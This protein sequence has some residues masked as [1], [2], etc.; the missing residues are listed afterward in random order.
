ML[1][2]KDTV[3][4]I[5]IYR[6]YDW[7]FLLFSDMGWFQCC[8]LMLAILTV[9]ALC[10]GNLQN[11]TDQSSE[12]RFSDVQSNPIACYFSNGSTPVCGNISFVFQFRKYPAIYVLSPDKHFLDNATEFSAMNGVKIVGDNGTAVIECE[13]GAGLSFVNSTNIALNQIT[14]LHCAAVQNSTSKDFSQPTFKL[15]HFRASLYFYQ[16]HNVNIT[17]VTISNSTNATGM[18]MYDTTGINTISNCTFYNNSVPKPNLGPYSGGGGVCVEFSYCRPGDNDCSN[19]SFQ[20]GNNSDSVYL[21]DNCEFIDNKANT[22]E[23]Y[24]SSSSFIL[25]YHKIHEAFGRGGGLSVFFKGSAKNNTIHVVNCTFKYNLA[26]WGGGLLIEFDDNSI[27]NVVL[28]ASSWFKHNHC[29]FNDS[30]GTGGGAIRIATQVYYGSSSELSGNQVTV[31]NC[32][33]K[34]NSALNGGALSVQPA[35]QENT[36]DSQVAKVTIENCTFDRNEGRLGSAVQV[37]LFQTIPKGKVPYIAFSNCV[38][39]NNSVEYINDSCYNTG[40]GAMYV[41]DVP[42]EFHSMV[43]FESNNGSAL[44]VVGTYLNFTECDALFESNRG[45]DGGGIA[46]LGAA[47]LLIGESTTMAFR[48]NYAQ[49]RGGAIFSNYISKDSMKTYVHCF[50]RYSNPFYGP[51]NWNSTFTFSKNWATLGR[52]IFSTSILPCAWSVGTGIS[53]N[54]TSIFCWNTQHWNYSGGNCSDEIFTEPQKFN[55]PSAPIKVFPGKVFVLPITAQDDLHHDVTKQTAYIAASANKS[56]AEVDPKF[57]Y[58]AHRILNITGIEKKNISL[59]LNT[60]GE[61]V[62]HINIAIEILQCP[63]GMKADSDTPNTTCQCSGNYGGNVKCSLEPYSVTLKSGY[64]IGLCDQNSNTTSTKLVI[65]KCPSQYCYLSY[66]EEFLPLPNTTRKLDPTVCSKQNRTGVLCGSCMKGYGPAVNSWNFNILCVECNDTHVSTQT[67]Y[68]VFSTFAPTFLLFLIIIIFNVKL[69]TGPVNAFILYAQM[70][71]SA[72]DLKT[73]SLDAFGEPTRQFL[74]AYHVL[75]GMFNLDIVSYLLDPFCIT[76]TFNSLDILQLNYIVALFPLLM[77]VVVVLFLKLKNWCSVKCT[78]RRI[79]AQRNRSSRRWRFA[80]S[81][82][83]A[84]VAFVLLSYTKFAISSAYVLVPSPLFD[85]N[86]TQVGPLRVLLAGQFSHSDP[87]YLTKYA[88]P[89][90]LVIVFFVAL[91]PLLLLGPLQWLDRLIV[92]K[93]YTIRRHWPA[94]KVNILLDTFQGCYKPRMRFFAGVYFIFR[95]AVLVTLATSEN[96]LQLYTIQQVLCCTV[97][98]LLSL[99]QPY[100]KNFFN[101]IDTL[102]FLN[103]A[104]LNALNMYIFVESIKDPPEKPK[105]AFIAQ[106]ILIYLPLL[107]VISYLLWYFVTSCGHKIKHFLKRSYL[108]CCVCCCQNRLN[109]IPLMDSAS[110]TM[111]NSARNTSLLFER[112]EEGNTYQP[113]PSL[114]RAIAAQQNNQGQGTYKSI[115][116]NQAVNACNNI[117]QSNSCAISQNKVN[118][119]TTK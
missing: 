39:F 24:K 91:P 93:C 51:E 79:Q 98:A 9:V 53:S 101:Y 30:F 80:S 69:T 88:L 10:A 59:E 81:T 65:G 74:Q 44:G 19:V 106:Y 89:A 43:H 103:L 77:I 54:I 85:E 115:A 108:F 5:L 35:L 95:I 48:N 87:Y 22:L 83:H 42:V 71:T 72:F 47:H 114:Q 90:I 14:L 33:F 76:S 86:N 6:G 97:I 67:C 113:S 63:P 118:S 41:S 11:E 112:A 78:W 66:Q 96:L 70:T 20:T 2:L 23:K 13:D 62:W 28:V 111:Q 27:F 110:G 34:E 37:A 36:A 3:A 26:L 105:A 31:R 60:V 75:Y 73:N 94:D 104:V 16:C 29:D 50:L 17:Q 7:C 32:T 4:G 92:S 61:R 117:Q 84:F 38:F 49:R 15:Q 102:T 82:V 68:Y 1:Y 58:V 18:V 107:Y 100:R 55:F 25:P 46:I 45:I 64:W 119:L 57:A 56:T 8:G 21:F 109:Y 52:S 40:L 99:L 116:S 12:Y